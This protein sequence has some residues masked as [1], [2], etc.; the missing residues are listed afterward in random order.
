MEVNIEGFSNSLM[1]DY[2][3][4]AMQRGPDNSKVMNAR[5]NGKSAFQYDDLMRM[6]DKLDENQPLYIPLNRDIH[7]DGKNYKGSDL[8]D[9]LEMLPY[10]RTQFSAALI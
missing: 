5:Q 9:L 6:K 10:L 2:L 8:R 1:N 4:E 7:I 3:M